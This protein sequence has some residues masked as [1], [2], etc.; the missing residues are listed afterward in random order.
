MTGGTM[1][2]RRKFLA[3]AALSSLGLPE[4]LANVRPVLNTSACTWQDDIR[5]RS[6]AIVGDIQRTSDGEM[7][8]ASRSQNDAARVAVL[9]AILNDKPDMILMLGDQVSTGDDGDDWSYFDSLM[10]RINASR[11]PVR[12]IMGNH[13]Y[14][15]DK[16]RSIN[17]FL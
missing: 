10:T 2:S 9:E 13:D 4:V 5:P 16:R 3:T 6:I 15:H 7:I 14:G 8:V 12:S 17:L 11:I 1:L